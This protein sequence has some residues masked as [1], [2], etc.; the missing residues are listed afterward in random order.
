MYPISIRQTAWIAHEGNS[1]CF[2]QVGVGLDVN[3]IYLGYCFLYYKAIHNSKLELMLPESLA[4]KK[5]K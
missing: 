5:Q 2:G 3:V 4:N 1:N